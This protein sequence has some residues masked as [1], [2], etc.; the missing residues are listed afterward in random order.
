MIKG[1]K[2]FIKTS[3]AVILVAAIGAGAAVYVNNG[4]KSGKEA[5]HKSDDRGDKIDLSPP[6]KDQSN[7]AGIHDNDGSSGDQTNNGPAEKKQ[8]TPVISSWG[9]N[10]S[11][12]KL[13]I[14]GF[15][16]G[17]VEDGGNCKFQLKMNGTVKT[18]TTTGALNA[19][20]TSCGQAA[21]NYG[22]LGKGVWQAYLIYSSETAQGTSS[23]V[24][25]EVK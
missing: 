12:N 18:V 5:T 19:S 4:D 21:F 24:P 23:P 13:E 11:S 6:S 8:V 2:R 14:N 16:Q 10:G 20:N 7:A 9:R 3:V 17:V 15:V 1:K 25:I 22:T